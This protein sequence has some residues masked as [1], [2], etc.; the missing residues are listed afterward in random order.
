MNISVFLA[1]GFEEIE[2]LRS[3]RAKRSEAENAEAKRRREA[4]DAEKRKKAAEDAAKR[5]DEASDVEDFDD[6]PKPKD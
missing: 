6:T 5:L 4:E 3:E 1:P 2:A